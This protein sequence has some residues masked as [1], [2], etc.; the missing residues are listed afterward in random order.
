MLPI[1]YPPLSLLPFSLGLLV[2]LAYYQFAFALLMA[3]VA[4]LIYWLLLR[5]GPRG[6]AL[7]FALYL[8]IGALATAQVRFDL[9]PAALT[10]LCLIPA[11]R[12]R[13][14]WA[15]VALAFGVLI[16]LYPLLLLPPL[17]I[18]EQHARGRL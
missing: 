18:A 15:Y 12:K 3:L 13:W 4:V 5:H 11:E 16:K 8:F 10:L 1:E 14:T 9:L 17:F 7:I 2:P 6:A